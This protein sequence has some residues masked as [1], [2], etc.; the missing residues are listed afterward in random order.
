MNQEVSKKTVLVLLLLTVVVSG[1][2]T[3]IALESVNG[4][5]AMFGGIKEKSAYVTIGV[6]VKQPEYKNDA[7]SGQVSLNIMK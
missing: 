2:G 4:R 6:N 3:W 7:V 1:I 5:S